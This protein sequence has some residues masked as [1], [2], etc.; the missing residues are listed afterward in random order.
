MAQLDTLPRS[1]DEL[2]TRTSLPAG[3]ILETL[4]VLELRGV[5]RQLPGQCFARAGNTAD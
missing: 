4:L 3:T 1:V 2:I 5:V